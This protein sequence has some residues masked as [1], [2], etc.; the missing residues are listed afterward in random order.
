MYK[1]QSCVCSFKLRFKLNENM[2]LE[3]LMILISLTTLQAELLL[4]GMLR[5]ISPKADVHI[6]EKC[7]QPVLEKSIDGFA[8]NACIYFSHE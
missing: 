3:F 4:L 2:N 5:I 6:R 8:K 1:I 7:T